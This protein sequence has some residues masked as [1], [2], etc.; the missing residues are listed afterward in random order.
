MRLGIDA[1]RALHGRGGVATYTR[2]LIRSL[3][4]SPRVDEITLFDLDQGRSKREAYERELGPLPTKVVVSPARTSQS[5]IGTGD[6][7]SWPNMVLPW[8]WS[9]DAPT[10][11][12][13][14]ATCQGPGVRSVKA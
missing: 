6:S 2:E 9:G 13:H 1:G 12:R 11:R 8:T 4:E 3:I 7:R 5:Q 14:G 10:S